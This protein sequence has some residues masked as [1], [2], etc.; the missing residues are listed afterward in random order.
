[1]CALKPHPP[2]W[3][4]SV[5]GI[6][7]SLRSSCLTIPSVLS[8]HFQC[9]WWP[10][11]MRSLKLQRQLMF[12]LLRPVSAVSCPSRLCKASDVSLVAHRVKLRQ[13]LKTRARSPSCKGIIRQMSHVCLRC[14]HHCTLAHTT[15]ALKDRSHYVRH[16]LP[17]MRQGRVETARII[18]WDIVKALGCRLE[19][20]LST[21]LLQFLLASLSVLTSTLDRY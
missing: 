9:P 15:G 7:I 16:L 5:F 18:T 17:A 10:S 2:V 3:P 19:M 6:D 20:C 21:R 4:T 1:M 11:L 14:L 8:S 13:L 12:R